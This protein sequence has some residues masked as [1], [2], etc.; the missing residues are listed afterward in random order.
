MH[1]FLQPTSTT[2]KEPPTTTTTTLPNDNPITIRCQTTPTTGR[3]TTPKAY[4]RHSAHQSHPQTTSAHHDAKWTN[5]HERRQP[6]TIKTHEQRR[7]SANTENDPNTTTLDRQRPPQPTSY[8]R[9]SPPPATNGKP[10]SDYGT[11]AHNLGSRPVTRS[12]HSSHPRTTTG[13]R[14]RRRRCA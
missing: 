7:A 8:E 11:T 12:A 6:P 5:A 10:P 9:C 13:V 14:K 2:P 1:L 4:K 3:A